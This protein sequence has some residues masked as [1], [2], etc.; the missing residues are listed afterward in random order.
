[1]GSVIADQSM[2]LDGYCTAVGA[3][4]ATSLGAWGERLLHAWMFRDDAT[5]RN[6]AV[7]DE[8]FATA[9]AAIMGRRMFDVGVEPWGEEPP[10]HMPVF[11]ITHHARE[12]LARRG[13]TTYHFVTGGID[14]VLARARAVAGDRDVVILGGADTIRQF[15][16]GGLLD[17]LRIHLVPVV[18]GGGTRLF[19]RT[20]PEP[21][22]LLPTR[23]V[24]AP[25]ATHLTFRV[26]ANH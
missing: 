17:E 23:V 14:D 19:D 3:R 20:G 25:G 9:G 1:M 21:I 12:P 11:V 24:G 7:R 22:D 26:L 13:G 10:F 16:V 5:G 4:G 6:A 15:L 2:S 8:L 18:L